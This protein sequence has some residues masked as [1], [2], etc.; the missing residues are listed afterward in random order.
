MDVQKTKC[1]IKRAMQI[2]DKSEGAVRKGVERGQIP[3]RRLGQRQI[4]FF[5]EELFQLL[6]G[7]NGLALPVS[8]KLQGDTVVRLLTD[9]LSELR[10]LRMALMKEGPE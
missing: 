3:H 1:G 8:E 9:I 7:A 4:F 2:L 5:E 6:N 10:R